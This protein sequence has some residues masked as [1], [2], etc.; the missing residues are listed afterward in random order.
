MP[1]RCAVAPRELYGSC[2][3][4]FL[5]HLSADRAGLL[6]GKFSVIALLEVDTDLP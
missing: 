3:A 1:R 5:N 6:G 2:G 4:H